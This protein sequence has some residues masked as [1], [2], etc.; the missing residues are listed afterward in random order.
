MAEITG[1]IRFKGSMGSL[2]CYWNSAAKKWCV[3]EKG[4]AN[5]NQI[6]NAPVFARTREN[7]S[8]FKACG[9]W[10]H[11]LR[12]SLMGLDHLNWGYYMKEVVKLSKVIQLKDNDSLR[13]FRNIASSKYKTLLTGINFNEQHP[14]NQVIARR[15]EID[16]DDERKEIIVSYPQFKSFFDFAWRNKYAYYRFTLTIGQLSD[17]TYDAIEHGYGSV[18]VGLDTK[19][20]SVFSEWLPKSADLVD[21]SLAASFPEDAIPPEDATVLVG[22]GI[23]FATSY[24]GGTI[25]WTKGDGTMAL[26]ACL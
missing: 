20:V 16:S 22:I 12:M 7:M 10:C 26:V 6:E 19:S 5:K 14:F 15:P 2:R 18:H 9:E 21:I 17:Y 8:E 23:E 25:S 24:S 1:P 3:G 4:G 13:G 11:L